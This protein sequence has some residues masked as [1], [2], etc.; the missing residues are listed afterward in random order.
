MSGT[1]S[2][3]IRS[4][5]QARAHGVWHGLTKAVAQRRSLIPNVEARLRPPAGRRGLVVRSELV[6]R[7]LSADVRAVLLTAGAGFGKTTLLTQWAELDSRPFA[8]VSLDRTDDDPAA[9]VADVMQALEAADASREDDPL[10]TAATNAPP[11][12]GLSRPWRAV[13]TRTRPFVLVLDDLHILRTPECLALVS[14]L[15]NNMPPGSQLAIAGRSEPALPVARWSVQGDLLRLG[16]E[17]LV[18][19]PAEASLLIGADLAL[20][21]G[22]LEALLG[23]TRGWAAGLG[24]AAIRLREQLARGAAARFDGQDRLVADYLRDE[25]LAPLGGEVTQFLTRTSMLDRLC[26]P[27]C[28]AV[29]ERSGSGIA[30]RDIERANVFVEPLDGARGWYR[31]HPL[32]R[33]MLRAELRLHGPALEAELHRRASAWHEAHGDTAEAIHYSRAAGDLKRAGDLIW[34]NVLPRLCH[35]ELLTLARWMADL[36]DGEIAAQ[37]TL[38]LAAA[39]CSL[40]RGDA[41]AARHW[42]ATADCGSYDG[43]LPGGPASPAAAAAILRAL[44][45]GDGVARMADDAAL[46]QVGDD[47][48]GSW[49]TVCGHLEG[50]ARRL[51]G[52]PDGARV[53]L[54]AAEKLSISTAAPMPLA[55]SLAQLAVL[56]A[57]DGNWDGAAALVARAREV[58]KQAGQRND[59]STIEVCAVS[60][61]VL[62]R[63]GQPADA[64]REGRRCARLLS[65][66]AHVPPWLAV[67]ARVLLARARLLVGDTSVAHGLLREARRVL[68]RMPDAGVLGRQVEETWRRAEAFRLAGVMAPAPL[69]RA[70]L[71]VLRFLP[72]HFSYREI[73]ERLHVSQCT[74]KS[75]ALSA[76]RKLDVSSRSQAVERASALG[77]IQ[78]IDGAAATTLVLTSGDRQS[79]PPPDRHP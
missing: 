42:A 46:G 22:E 20:A 9:L 58:S 14:S 55:G 26:G 64:G 65:A 57:D 1:R 5:P 34:A 68:A 38:A 51:S 16:A 63:L 53:S 40:E 31:C 77:L 29:L 30:L 6:A 37:P 79:E 36:G 44:V 4:S 50:V 69:S 43:A 24:M 11:P 39:L 41:V 52:D 76:Y 62:A 15:V 78:G 35:G 72:T 18:M 13:S 17:E 45:A 74:V 60:A 7:L 47:A 25:V 56:A 28:D 21:P 12:G 32:L 10:P 61:L 59:T 54:A 48:A 2:H 66:A 71:R 70:E 19:T 27:L 8:W 23:R 67:D 33:D 73:G 75:Q 3:T 49:R